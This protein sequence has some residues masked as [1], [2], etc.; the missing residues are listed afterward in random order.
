MQSYSYSS[1]YKLAYIAITL[2]VYYIS[3]IEKVGIIILYDYS[4]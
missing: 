4:T 1:K 3:C 2:N